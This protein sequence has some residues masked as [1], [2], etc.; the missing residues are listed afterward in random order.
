MY[1]AV[2]DSVLDEAIEII[3]TKKDFDPTYDNVKKYLDK[4]GYD[5]DYTTW[6]VFTS[7]PSVKYVSE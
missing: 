2:I 1:I 4:Q 5:T 3:K 6:T 7:R